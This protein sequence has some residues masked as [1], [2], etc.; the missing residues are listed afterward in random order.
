M[1]QTTSP[2]RERRLDLLAA[3][4]LNAGYGEYM[5]GRKAADAIAAGLPPLLHVALGV[6]PTPE[7]RLERCRAD[8]A[9][10]HLRHAQNRDATDALAFYR[11]LAERVLALLDGPEAEIDALFDGPL[12]DF[13]AQMDIWNDEDSARLAGVGTSLFGA[14]V[15]FDDEPTAIRIDDD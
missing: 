15:D 5:V 13:G 6:V 8:V 14:A 7:T 11:T 12:P 2:S 1:S 4:L 9:L 10:G 3:F